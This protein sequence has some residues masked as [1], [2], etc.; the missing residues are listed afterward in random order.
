MIFQFFCPQGHLLEADESQVGQQCMCPY[1]RGAFLVP[2]PARATPIDPPD[3]L[4]PPPREPPV[5]QSVSA[6]RP[7]KEP[8]LHANEN[9]PSGRSEAAFPGI[10]TEPEPAKG[11]A[12][13]QAPPAIAQETFPP[14]VHILCPSGHELETPREM[15]GQDAL[16]PHCQAQF[17]LRYEDSLEHRQQQAD[18]RRQRDEA[19]ARAWMKWSIL[20]AVV[21]VVGAIV[22]IVM[23]ARL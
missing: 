8:P 7:L 6:G 3:G 19:I 9:D 14:L 23:A 22:M 12:T 17:L 10:Q 1:C 2:A 5:F 21:V 11:K 20:A 4:Q 18:Q 13:G 16:C 15:L